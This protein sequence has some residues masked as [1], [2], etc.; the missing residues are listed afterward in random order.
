MSV[1]KR[2]DE[3]ETLGG[4]SLDIERT[5][6]KQ[7]RRRKMNYLERVLNIATQS[8]MEYSTNSEEEFAQLRENV[9]MFLINEMM[10][11]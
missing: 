6:K 1:E 2:M 11:L 10:E 4:R 7:V 9:Q 5:I 8:D 3:V